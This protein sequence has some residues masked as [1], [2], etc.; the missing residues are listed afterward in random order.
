MYIQNLLDTTIDLFDFQEF[1]IFDSERRENVEQ[2][3]PRNIEIF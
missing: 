2:N 3:G 1:V